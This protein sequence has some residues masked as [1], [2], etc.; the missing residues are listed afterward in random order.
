[1]LAFQQMPHLTAPDEVSVTFAQEAQ[2][3]CALAAKWEIEPDG[4]GVAPDVELAA[5]LRGGEERAGFRIPKRAK[6]ALDGLRALAMLRRLLTVADAAMPFLLVDS[7]VSGNVANQSGGA[8]EI[9]MAHVADVVQALV[10]AAFSDRAAGSI[11]Y[12]LEFT[13]LS[14]RACTLVGYP[15]VSAI[16][17]SGHQLG[18][19]ADSGRNHRKSTCH[20]FEDRVG[21]TLSQRWQHEHVEAPH[22]F[23]DV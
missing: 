8:M 3:R 13:N 21:Y 17:L 14:G 20:G 5:I 9:S 23:W 22:H 4:I 1:M 6:V 10:L 19:A 7:T 11:Y 18:S 2:H 12:H 16:N 15:G